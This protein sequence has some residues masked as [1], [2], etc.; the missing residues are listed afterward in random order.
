MTNVRPVKSAARALMI[1]ELYSREQRGLSV[2]EITTKLK[3]PQPSVSMLLKNFVELGY[4]EYDRVNRKY[5]PNIRV[6]LLGMWIGHRFTEMGMVST[7]LDILHEE[8]DETAFLGIQNGANA[9][10]IMY[11]KGSAT[12]GLNIKSGQFRSLTSSAMGRAILAIKGDEEIAGWVRRCNA[13]ASDQRHIISV[14]D[15]KAIVA[16]TRRR[17]YASTS[18]DVTEGQGAFA[19]AFLSPIGQPLAVGV[20]GPIDRMQAKEEIAVRALRK[21]VNNLT[22]SK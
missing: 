1:F 22:N 21:F 13:E 19:I 10:Y 5:T 3:I 11:Q 7:H 9:Q 17:G 12:D 15:F 6:A 2:G 18:G 20:G 16:E 4:L 8:V 14:S